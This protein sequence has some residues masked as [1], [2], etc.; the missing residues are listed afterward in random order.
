MISTL[1]VLAVMTSH[2]FIPDAQ[3]SAPAVLHYFDGRGRAEPVRWMLEATGTEYTESVVRNR[4][5]MDR[6]RSSGK[7]LFGQVPMLEIDGVNIV[8]TDAILRYLAR[9]H[10]MLGADLQE[11]AK[12]DMVHAATQDIRGSVLG[13]PFV[14]PPQRAVMLQQAFQNTLPKYLAPIEQLL[15]SSTTGP[16]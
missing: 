12:I 8:Q 2:A 1:C 10:D 5:A 15:R 4:E 3:R 7:L 9:K 6:L 14:P 16:V 13:L 11:S